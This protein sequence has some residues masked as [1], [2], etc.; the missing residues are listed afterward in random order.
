VHRAG[1][2]PKKHQFRLVICGH[3]AVEAGAVC[4]VLMV[5]GHVMDATLA[6]LVIAS[7]TGLLAV[8]PA[9]AVTFTRYARHLA[10]RWTS[11]VVLG[12]CAFAA[13]AAIHPSHY[14]GA[15]TEAALTGVGAALFSLLVSVTPVGKWIDGL[16]EGFLEPQPALD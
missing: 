6:H 1:A 11:A 3:K 4:L 13:D 14:P 12:V 2:S 7:K 5:Q 16:A 10:N 15:Y 8:A 9:M